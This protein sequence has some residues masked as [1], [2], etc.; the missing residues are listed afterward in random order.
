MNAEH[1]LE[2]ISFSRNQNIL[3]GA[4]QLVNSANWTGELWY[5]FEEEDIIS[6]KDVI[7]SNGN[8]CLYYPLPISVSAGAFLDTG[9]KYLV[10]NDVGLLAMYSVGNAE[11]YYTEEYLTQTSS[12]ISNDVGSV[13]HDRSILSISVSNTNTST[14]KA[15]TGSMDCSIKIWDIETFIPEISY[16]SAHLNYV[17]CVRFQ[18]SSNETGDFGS[19]FVSASLDGRCLLW[20]R[21]QSSSARVLY[22]E[23]EIRFTSM[24]WFSNCTDILFLGCDI[25]K[26]RIV[27]VRNSKE[28]ILIQDFSSSR[29]IN[30]I[31]SFSRDSKN[32]LSVCGN[33]R[34]F[35]IYQYSDKLI[36]IYCNEDHVDYVRDTAWISKKLKLLSCSWDSRIIKH[37]PFQNNDSEK[38]ESEQ[39]ETKSEEDAS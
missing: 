25:G 12:T 28:A 11:S 34:K 36:E 6:D 2:F 38:L 21:R 17:T 37:S 33:C 4:S 26:L 32:Y 19:V 31:R 8:K 22:A 3:I 10:G 9:T 27:D 5:F 13:E 7:S 1:Q 24:E 39:G 15:V 18:G 35:K 20:D 16:D 29:S 23:E 30:T 14:P